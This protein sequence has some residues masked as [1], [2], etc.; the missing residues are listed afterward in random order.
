MAV[1]RG[2]QWTNCLERGSPNPH[3]VPWLPIPFTAK[4]LA[5]F[6]V[7]GCGKWFVAMEFG[8]WDNHAEDWVESCAERLSAKAREAML[9]ALA[10]YRH[11]ATAV[12]HLWPENVR[13]LAA[14]HSVAK[15]ELQQFERD[16]G[17]DSENPEYLKRHGLEYH[18]DFQLNNA[19]EQDAE[20]WRQWRKAV[21]RHLLDSQSTLPI[22]ATASPA[23]AEAKAALPLPPAEMRRP[24]MRRDVLAP[25]IKAATNAA[26]DPTDRVAAWN[27]LTA[28]AL[29]NEKVHPLLGFAEKTV[30]YQNGDEVSFLTQDAFNKRWKRRNAKNTAERC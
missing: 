17:N 16:S 22:G 21:V 3:D 11:A 12:D 14:D 24:A 29:A 6:M 25:L 23:D 5:A 27:A 10:A 7:D 9:D 30:K 1:G 2:I 28:M 8:E 4:Q 26:I 19:R 18:L 15:A 13:Q 20:T